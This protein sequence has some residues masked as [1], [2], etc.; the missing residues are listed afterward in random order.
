MLTVDIHPKRCVCLSSL[1]HLF[2]VQVEPL[3]ATFTQRMMEPRTMRMRSCWLLFLPILLAIVPSSTQG[4]AIRPSYDVGGTKSIGTVPLDRGDTVMRRATIVYPTDDGPH[5]LSPTTTDNF[6]SH[7][8]DRFHSM[9]EFL[10][11]EALDR[12][13]RLAV[14]FSPLERAIQ[15]QDIE[16]VSVISIDDTSIDIEAMLCEN[17]GCVSLSV[18]ISFPHSCSGS[19]DYETCVVDNIGTLDV[20]ANQALLQSSWE[21][22]L[23]EQGLDVDQQKQLLRDP[24]NLVYPSWWIPAT[25]AEDCLQESNAILELLND[26]EFSQ[27]VHA[28][29]TRGLVQQQQ[30]SQ[31]ENVPPLVELAVVTAV[32]PAG[33]ML[34]AL[35]P[36]LDV[37]QIPLA[38]ST[39]AS[40]VESLRTAVLE[41]VGSV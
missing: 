16:H 10:Q 15:L 21:S 13:A 37:H 6:G 29:A 3:L 8:T 11:T 34:C 28:L 14:A 2:G 17:D 19:D 30:Q 5:P 24:T 4:F 33:L 26:G 1:S 12:L 7:A 22:K 39:P 36:E 23:R 41:L 31:E 20:R 27:E 38:F 40:T 18:P 35:N 32:G 9:M 25:V